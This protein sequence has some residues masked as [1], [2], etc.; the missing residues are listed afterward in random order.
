MPT[1]QSITHAK[2]QT[3]SSNRHASRYIVASLVVLVLASVVWYLFTSEPVVLSRTGYE[4]AKALYAACNLEDPARL[5]AVM[6]KL[7][8][9]SLSPDERSKVTLI[10]N[11]AQNGK[12]QDAAA[13]ARSLLESQDSP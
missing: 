4:L 12:W 6:G 8:E 5:T 1:A 3:V 7:E 11:L 13:R 10:A 2:R 9:E